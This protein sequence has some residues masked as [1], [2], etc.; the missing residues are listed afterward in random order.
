MSTRKCDILI[1]GAG[2]TG[3]YFG[4]LM[5]RRGHAVIII[6][7]DRREDVGQRLEVIHFHQKTMADLEIPPPIEPPELLF[8]YKGVYVSRL[9]LFLQRMYG[10]V[11]S[12][13]VQ[14]EFNICRIMQSHI[15]IHFYHQLTGIIELVERAVLKRRLGGGT[16]I[17]GN[18]LDKIGNGGRICQRI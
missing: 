7:K 5:A 1:I 14:F 3:V 15:I 8:P 16:K 12:A 4:W 2:T 9:P 17:I 18:I 11:E 10:L 13:G 6:D